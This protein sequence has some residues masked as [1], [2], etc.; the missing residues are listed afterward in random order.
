LRK[1]SKTLASLG[2]VVAMVSA[3]IFVVGVTNLLSAV[4]LGKS[5]NSVIGT[6]QASIYLASSTANIASG[7]LLQEVAVLISGVGTILLCLAMYRGGFGKV[8]GAIGIVA[9]VLAFPSVMSSGILA[10]VTVLFAVWFILV[11]LKLYRITS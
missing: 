6:S 9:G 5:Y 4:P 3:P 10:V 8:V 1:A 7:L 11:G 2:A